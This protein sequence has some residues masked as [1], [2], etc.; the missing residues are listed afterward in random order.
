MATLVL[1][2]VGAAV[3]GGL[4]G[5]ALGLSSAVIGRAVGSTIGRVLDQRIM[6]SGSDVVDHG[7]LNRMRLSGAP[8]GT[9]IAQVFGSCRV[10]G[11]TFWATRFK[12]TKKV[13]GGGGKGAPSAPATSEYSY[14]VSIAV[15]VCE[16]P[17]NRIG[18]IWADGAEIQARDY[19]VR[20][21]KGDEDQLPDPL[22]EAIEGIDQTPAYRGLAYVVFEDLPLKDFGN[23]VPQFSF[24]VIRSVQKG[25]GAQGQHPSAIIKGVAIIPGTGEYSLATDPVYID[26]GLGGT[27]YLNMTSPSGEPDFPTSMAAV[28]GEIPNLESTLLVSSWFG[29][30]LRC[31]ECK[32]KPK[33]E[34]TD[35]DPVNMPWQVAGL[36]R[37]TADTIQ[38]IGGNSVYGG[39]P[40]DQSVLQAIRHLSSLEKKIVF[41]PF[42]LMEITK[43]NQKS[44]PWS[45][46]GEQPAFPWRGRITSTRAPSVSETDD[47]TAQAAA[48]VRTF[49]GECSANNFKI[50]N[51]S[52]IYSG[53]DE[54]GYRRFILHNAALCAAAGGVDAFCIGSEMR[55]LTQIRGELHSFPS[56]L[57]LIALSNDV[58]SLLPHAKIGYAADWSEYFGYHAADNNIYFH[59]DDLW[60]AA[61]IDFIGIDNYMPVADWRNDAQHADAAAR[62]I[63]SQDYLR[64]NIEG[65]EGYDWYYPTI[66]AREAQRRVPIEDGV[67]GE[68][69]IYRYKDIRNWWALEHHNRIDDIRIATPTRWTPKSKPIWFTEIGCAAIDKGANQPNRFFDPKSD[70]SG[71]PYYSNGHRDDLM[72]A[73]YLSAVLGYWDD[74]SVNPLSDVYEG[75]M[76]D[77]SKTHV[78]AWDAR[79][80][81]EFPNRADIWSD[82][83]NYDKGHWVAGRIN[84]QALAD[85]ISMICERAGLFAY[86]V[87][88]VFALVRGYE[89]G[90]IQSARAS[91][92]PLLLA[93]GIDAVD[94]NGKLT[95][96]MRK[97]ASIVDLDSADFVFAEHIF[98]RENAPFSDLTDRIQLS[99]VSASGSYN[100]AMVQAEWPN[101]YAPTVS[102]SELPIVMEKYEAQAL[103]EQWQAESR[104]ARDSVS[105]ALPP[106][107]QSVFV[108]DIV[109][110]GQS[111]VHVETFRVDKIEDRGVRYLEA[112]KTEITTY[113][114]REISE[115]PQDIRRY[116][117]TGPAFSLFLDLPIQPEAGEASGARV[118]VSA[119]PWKG[120]VAVYASMQDQDYR[121]SGVVRAP[122]VI[123]E[124]LTALEPAAGAVW[125]NS[126]ALRVRVG[127]GALSSAGQL[128]V[129]NGANIAAIGDGTVDGWEIIQF[130]NAVLVGP[131]TYD[132]RG[133]LRGQ[134]S[135]AVREAWPAGST[136]VLL[137]ETLTSISVNPDFA[138]LP[139]HYRIGPAARPY[140]DPLFKKEIWTVRGLAAK[141]FKPVHVRASISEVGLDASWV[142]RTR[143]G[144]DSW[145]VADVPVGEETETYR[146]RIVR[147]DLVLLDVSV[148]EPQFTVA[149]AF[150]GPIQA[151]DVFEVAQVSVSFGHGPWGS[152]EITS[153]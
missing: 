56:V 59:L 34:Q 9:A 24:E 141:P 30:D 6:G 22:I 97:D 17:I 25:Q 109:R 83:R 15:G 21:Y 134:Q 36:T 2:A 144:G 136:F 150:V 57:E 42:I 147:N 71:L 29:D 12:E 139:V 153:A 107:V 8:E 126:A 3:G 142:R 13:T 104:V 76:I 111:P 70:E 47:Q 20:I 46:T 53:P 49:F 137:D 95:F 103:V 78:W 16:G 69:W 4:G 58:R 121:L 92:Q 113:E 122:S 77:T 60:A 32:I 62:T 72:Q 129:L 28:C 120:D 39:T 37:K 100:A 90:Q 148:T 140:D 7:R 114:P 79:P 74:P 41:Y 135:T 127:Q 149:N 94:R 38:K 89:I 123:G 54:W 116:T 91:L 132:I 19:I 101:G 64:K 143:I 67:H 31:G 10:S 1:G 11:S 98:A 125:D 23:R 27:K 51:G 88:Q 33:V 105:F 106:S 96:L 26:Q 65:G 151:G 87:T 81:P 63:Y 44:D 117:P 102:Q 14:S 84:A 99:Y 86:D 48:A 93:Y 40:T 18:R 50:L 55:G 5:S 133:R 138:G 130:Q 128:A 45:E 119:Q 152:C 43:G 35:E 68:T 52:V 146:V 108:G 124:T 61:N 85:V 115:P 66:E 118:A 82:G 112:S 110:F 145:L 131:N 80:W 75:A 73:S